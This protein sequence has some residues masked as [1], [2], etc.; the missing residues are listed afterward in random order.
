M[1]DQPGDVRLLGPV[2]DIPVAPNEHREITFLICL[3]PGG[4]AVRPV[5]LQLYGGDRLVASTTLNQ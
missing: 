1:T 2:H 4:G 3:K 5:Q